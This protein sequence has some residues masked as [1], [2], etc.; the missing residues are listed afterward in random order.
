M[1]RMRASVIAVCLSVLAPT[2]VFAQDDFLPNAFAAGKG[3]DWNAAY[4]LVGLDLLA[5][6]LITWTRLR[7][8]GEAE[9]A[10]YVAFTS[11]HPDWPG[12][13]RLRG[14]GERS[15][16]DTTP[17]Q[18]VLSW[19]D[20]TEPETGTGGYRLAIALRETG[21]ADEARE[22]IR[23]IWLKYGLTEEEHEMILAEFGGDLADLHMQRADAML[24]RWKVDDAERLLPELSSDN[25][26]LIEARLALIRK[27]SDWGE[28]LS[29]VPR[30]LL[31]DAGLAYDRFNF[32][33][34]RG[35]R[36]DAVAILTGRTDDADLLAQPFRWAGWRRSHARWEMREGR[37]DSAYH[38]ASAHHLVPDDGE[39]YADLEWLAGY[40]ALRYLDRPEDALTHFEDVKA[41][42]D[43]PISNSRASY[44]MGR[45]YEALGDATSA[46]VAYADAANYQ[47]AFYGLLAAEKLGLPL[48]ASLAGGESFPPFEGSTLAQ[49]ETVKAAFLL[50]DAGERGSAVLFF[51]QL[52]RTLDRT[53]IGTLGAELARRNDPFFML[54]LGKS[55]ASRG[56]I[57]P[58]LYF[59]LHDLRNLDLPVAPELALS[60]ARRESEFNYVVGSAVGALGLMQLMPGT[61]EEVA[62]ELNLP[63]SRGRLTED[64]QYNATLGSKY[65]SMLEEEFGPTPAMIAAGYNAG[66]SRPRDWN[67]ERGDP[68]LGEIDVVDWIEAIPFRETRN[69]VQRVTES[70]PIYQAR[71]GGVIGP[72]RFTELLIGEKPILRPVARPWGD[73]PTAIVDASDLA[74]TVVPRPVARD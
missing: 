64:W 26:A 70:I 61:A 63:Y 29:A 51:A 16:L 3:G 47:T 1:K 4:Q 12:M 30:E 71:L 74:P 41:A 38:L 31:T 66:P 60:I 67:D 54:I 56:M 27:S 9:F 45:T 10:D 65:L 28:K 19:F 5:H 43:S 62:G 69:Y 49:D 2:G 23:N 57:I 33:S 25:S 52:G 68:R 40:I 37:Y 35:D 6:D 50:L 14:E 8:E 20:G 17:A 32:L 18:E 15:I 44:W 42:V 55:A 59:P 21:L 39:Q 11:A 53:A 46:A 22:V 13:A 73:D 58:D 24:W 34:D 7:E 72:V 36:T 48:D